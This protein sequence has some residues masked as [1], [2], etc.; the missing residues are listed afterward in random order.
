MQQRDEAPTRF[1]LNSRVRVRATGIHGQILEIHPGG[2][3]PRYRVKL[4]TRSVVVLGERELEPAELQAFRLHHR[5]TRTGR[6]LYC[7]EGG[8]A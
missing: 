4:M 3:E 1:T 2:V 8:R 5:M 7:I 6:P